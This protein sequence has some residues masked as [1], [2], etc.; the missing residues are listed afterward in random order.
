MAKHHKEDKIQQSEHQAG[1]SLE[2]RYKLA[3]T[4]GT[5][6]ARYLLNKSASE[7]F[8][9][10]SVGTFLHDKK[11]LKQIFEYYSRNDI[12][13]A[14]FRYA[15][16]R[17]IT[18]IRYFR[19][20]F[21]N[22]LNPNDILP[23]TT[24]SLLEYG[25]FWPS[26]HG[27]I[28]RY[29]ST[30]ARISDIVIELDYK[31]NW[32]TCFELTYPIIEMLQSRNA[33]FKLKF[34]GHSSVHI[35]IPAESLRNQ[36]FQIDHVEF[37]RRLSNVI[38]K[39]LKEPK[40]LD[41]SFYMYDH[42][43]R[44]AYSINENTGLVS[45]PFN[46]NDYE[47][48]DPIQARPDKVVPLQGWWSIPKDASERMQDF[49]QY[50]T[51]G[52]IATSSQAIDILPT[53]KWQPDQKSVREAKQR[54]RMEAREFLPNEG[55]YDRMT[56]IGQEIIDLREILLL[57]D[58]NSKTALRTLRHLHHSDQ[59]FDI[60]SIATRFDVDDSDLGVL[61]KWEQSESAFKYYSREDVRLVIYA[62][63]EKRKIRVGGQEKLV[64]LQEPMDILPLVAYSHIGTDGMSKGY[65][66]F[67][68]TNSR[69]ERTGE[70]PITCDIKIEFN[71][72]NETDSIIEA[73]EPVF[74]L[75]SG[76]GITFFIFFDGVRGFNVIIP[77]EALPE[78]A[79]LASTRH[80]TILNRLA[81]HLKRVMRMPGASCTLVRDCNAMTLMPYSIHPQT[82][83]VCVPILLS[84]LRSFHRKDARL[85]NVEVDNHW[86][87]VPDDAPDV[88]ASFFKQMAF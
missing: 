25:K 18:Y 26:L 53:D 87:D 27:T 82:G 14:M 67:H 2:E 74:S 63:A 56:R 8:P 46:V 39:K 78:E 42:Y 73:V 58:V 60:K 32:K 85:E 43:L 31:A 35:I 64:F 16:G 88:M 21:G 45:L 84:D 75:L 24:V 4:K 1:L 65:P 28:S 12:Q 48:F 70:I 49:I 83:L 44:L 71:T 76:F 10:N 22:L 47:K 11:Q 41:K 23:L 68:F 40:Y 19:P 6:L 36:G 69:Y 9:K 38:S 77:Y 81:P 79:K 61:W 55:F 62:L 34:S 30:G 57:D 59:K 52:Q 29:N 66:S 80:E 86:W 37:F 51:R 17:K 3:V 54:K 33:V 20:Q 7:I 50:I 13:Q 72:K 15:I 5:E